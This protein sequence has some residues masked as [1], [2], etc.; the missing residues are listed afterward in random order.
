MPLFVR[1]NVAQQWR[2]GTELSVSG[3][4]IAD[5]AV[6]SPIHYGNLS[7]QT[8]TVTTLVSA[9]NI[10]AN[11][12]IS[13][14]VLNFG[15]RL[16]N[17]L[18]CFYGNAVSSNATNVY[19][20]GVDSN[21]LRYTVEDGTRRHVFY[22]NTT[23]FANIDANGFES[24]NLGTATVPA[25]SFT[26]DNDTGMYSPGA[27]V[28]AFSAGGSSI[29]GIT[30]TGLGIFTN[31]P[32][33]PLHVV[34]SSKFDGK[35]EIM[36]GT[37]SGA[38]RGI[39]LWTVADTNW[40]I[41]MASSGA[42]KS[43]SNGTAVAGYNFSDNSLR[44]RVANTTVNGFIWENSSEQLLMS[45]RGDTAGGLYVTGPI[46]TAGDVTAYASDQR[47]KSNIQL[48][49]NALDKVCA[50]NGVRFNWKE[51]GPQPMRGSDVGLLAQQV[52]AVL[53]EAVKAAPFD[54]DEKGASKSGENYLTIDVSG[55]KLIALL[56][57]SV[58]ELRQENILMQQRIHA[59]ELKIDQ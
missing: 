45:L 59:L 19:G 37:N 28:L 31:S 56:V 43:Y 13:T 36:G 11:N 46:V 54:L 30:T 50:L 33:Q 40:S 14:G 34:G 26:S 21:V 38:S 35:L 8:A 7:G 58:K 9:A 10:T 41:Y 51:D 1:A 18:V 24:A 39:S 17:T 12:F 29:A 2:L 27:N 55:N 4:V 22:G 42:N 15:S 53:P 32:S 47:L 25:Y 48:L 44:H 23:L 49:E 5:T 6:R 57:E 20:I 3:N 52:Q 16:A